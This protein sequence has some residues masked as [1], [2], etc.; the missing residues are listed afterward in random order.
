[1]SGTCEQ[2]HFDTCEAP[3]NMLTDL[4]QNVCEYIMSKKEKDRQIMRG[5]DER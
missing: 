3:Y 4:S 5:S 1:M 2:K